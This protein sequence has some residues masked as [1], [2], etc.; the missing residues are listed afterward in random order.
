MI[1]GGISYLIYFMNASEK[2]SPSEAFYE[3]LLL[4]RSAIELLERDFFT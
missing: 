2:Y 4:M 3:A 1:C